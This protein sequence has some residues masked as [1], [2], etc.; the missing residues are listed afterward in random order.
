MKVILI[1]LAIIIIAILVLYND[2]VRAK[3]KVKEKQSSIDVCLNQRFDLI[4][5]LVET[6]KGYAGHENDLLNDITRLRFSYINNNNDLKNGENLNNKMNKLLVVAENYPDLKANS[7][8]LSLQN[9]L[10]KIEDKLQV[11]RQIYNKSVTNYN[12]KIQTIPSNMVASL[13][14][15]KEEKLFEIEEFKK[16]NINLKF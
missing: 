9:S 10:S 5:N 15:F 3:N 6:V 11:A 4:P 12:N 13:F 2:L 14:G 7:Q 8:F 16:D 1:V